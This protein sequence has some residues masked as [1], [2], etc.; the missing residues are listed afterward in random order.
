MSTLSLSS[1]TPEEG[2]RSF[3]RW[4]LRIELRTFGRAVLFQTAE[5]SLQ[6]LIYIQFCIEKDIGVA[7]MAQQLRT[8]VALVQGLGL[9]HSSYMETRNHL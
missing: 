4:L 3:H 5:P 1:D 6:P 7:E 2:I 9:T 8:L